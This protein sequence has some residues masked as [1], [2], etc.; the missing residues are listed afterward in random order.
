MQHTH[1]H[2][3]GH[4]HSH[5]QDFG[6]MPMAPAM[7]HDNPW[8]HP[9]I[10]CDMDHAA[11]SSTN[12][13]TTTSPIIFPPLNA[14][15]PSL[16]PS[17]MPSTSSTPLSADPMDMYTCNDTCNTQV[18]CCVDPSC[19][20]IPTATGHVHSKECQDCGMDEL[21][22]WACTKEGC[23]A[24]Q[25][26]VSYLASGNADTQLDCCT[27]TDCDLPTHSGPSNTIAAH[28]HNHTV[29]PMNTPNPSMFTQQSTWTGQNF[30]PSSTV[31]SPSM[32]I[33]THI[34]HW[35]NCHRIFN[36]M[37][38]LLGHVASDHLGAPGFM[39]D[40]PKSLEP[41]QPV[42]P[43]PMPISLPDPVYPIF[44]P[45]SNMLNG[46]NT[47]ATN[48]FSGV[49]GQELLSCLWDDCLP[50]PECTAPA[51]EACPTHANMPA[52]PIGGGTHSHNTATGEP[53]SPQTMLRHVLEEHLGVPG[54]ILGWDE[55]NTIPLPNNTQVTQ[56]H[57][58]LHAH[59]HH[60]HLPTPSS[61][62]PSPSPPPKPLICLWP[63]CTHPD[64]FPDPATL[65][66][67]LSEEHVGK[68]K[69]SY[70]CQWDNCDRT[71]RSRQ[72]VLRHLQSHTGHRPFVC[73]VCEQAFGEAAPLAAHMRRHA[74]ESES[75]A[76]TVS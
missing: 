3:H 50:L 36:S 73:P 57:D 67:H 32:V 72:K 22:A 17:A 37:P 5:S 4:V 31:A 74:Q 25:N 53:F 29:T 69:D 34:C 42:L 9:Y 27:Q 48:P 60:I 10:C 21:E 19:D 76:L 15:M 30:T 14:Q 43:P 28:Q 12:V 18:D 2:H 46:T 45:L 8:A 47:G 52:H 63:G 35:Q 24:I 26:Y 55:S 23:Q 59:H 1:G 49:P 64:A 75:L 16:L 11:S 68:G 13:S 65:M 70:T 20:P 61:S 58:R 56:A 40:T 41:I 6:Q 54:S 62:Q 66:A 38:D 71:F 7:T 51:P 44:D 39:T 33:P